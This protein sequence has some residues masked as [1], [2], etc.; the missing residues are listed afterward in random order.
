MTK[1]A[2]IAASIVIIILFL[3]FNSYMVM[4]A[5]RATGAGIFGF[6]FLIGGLTAVWRSKTKAS[7]DATTADDEK[8]DK[9]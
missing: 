7:T 2:K 3:L 6:I 5:K 9:T 8:L 1:F 4:E